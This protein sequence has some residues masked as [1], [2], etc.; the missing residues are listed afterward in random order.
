MWSVTW[1]KKEDSQHILEVQ[2][3]AFSKNQE[4]YTETLPPLQENITDVER[5]IEAEEI[6]V[7]VATQSEKVI[8]SVRFRSDT[9]YCTVYYLA[10]DPAYSKLSV[11]RSLMK[12][13]E[14]EVSNKGHNKIILEVGLLDSP[15]IEFYI[16]LGYRPFELVV[17]HANGM[18]QV[19][20]KKTL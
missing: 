9:D 14:E 2:T 10:V 19:R 18:D 1:A 3:K 20:F 11:G 6:G 12:R 8:G 17:D 15:A 13:V 16:R 5:E 4:H 7:L